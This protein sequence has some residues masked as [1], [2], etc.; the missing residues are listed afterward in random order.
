M[1]RMKLSVC[2]FWVGCAILAATA[3]GVTPAIQGQ[4]QHNRAALRAI[5]ALQSDQS[6]YPDTQD[7][8]QAYARDACQRH[9]LMG[10]AAHRQGDQVARDSEWAGS[11][12]CGKGFVGAIRMMQPK[13]GALAK[14]AVDYQPFEPESWFW[15]ADVEA[16]VNPGGAI[17]LMTQG[18][19]LRPR[20]G[21]GWYRLAQL[22]EQVGEPYLAI[23]AYISACD[24][25]NQG[26]DCYVKAGSLYERLG[27]VRHAIYYYRLSIFEGAHRRADW[28]EG[29]FP[30]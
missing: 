8:I 27:D 19:R 24:Y 15:L 14:L 21:V 20:D 12:R 11:I 5:A 2:R 23:D 26:S 7:A 22:Y 17:E 16:D 13:G 18:L 3:L 1:S 25:L 9:W 10:L 28:L 4:S 30:P 29:E 6:D